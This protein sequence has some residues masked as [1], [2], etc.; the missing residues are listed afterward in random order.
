M[1]NYSTFRQINEDEDFYLTT[2]SITKNGMKFID[3]LL[4]KDLVELQN[5]CLNNAIN[6][7][8]V[9]L[10]RPNPEIELR[11]PQIVPVL[12]SYANKRLF[13][14]DTPGLGKTVMS[15]ESYASYKLRKIKNNEEYKK[16][17]VV[18][19]TDHVKGFSNEWKSFGINLLPLFN[20][21]LKIERVLSKNNIEDFD[22]IILN[23]DSL[24]T[25]A[26]IEHYVTNKELYDFAIFDE[27]TQI[28]NDKSVISKVTDMIVNKY[29]GGLGHVI[30]L[31][32]TSFEKNV[33]D[34]Y[35]QF[36]ILAPKLIPSKK[37]LDS[38]YVV[39]KGTNVYARHYINSNNTSYE[40]MV[41]H[42]TA[43]IINYVN[44]EELKERL[45]YYFI[46]RS[47]SEFYKD[48]PKHINTLHPVYMTKEQL[49]YLRSGLNVS[50]INS[51]TTSNP[52]AKFEISNTP[53]LR[54]IIDF[55]K[56]VEQDRPIIYVFNKEAQ[57][58]IKQELTK[59]NYR[60]D[61]LNGDTK[62]KNE[63][64][65]KFNSQELDMLVTNIDSAINLPTSD[66]ILF[67]DIPTNPQKTTQICGRIDRNND[68]DVKFYDFFCYMYSPEMHNI[69]VNGYF[70]EKHSSK[71]TGQESTRY[72]ELLH[73][74]KRELSDENTIQ[75]YITIFENEE[76][77]VKNLV[78]ET[79]QIN[80][81][82][83]E[84]SKKEGN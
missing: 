11:L 63:M 51:P 5:R 21:S 67:Y 84:I 9:L 17:I 44:Q 59:L 16:V 29:Q 22:G 66:R 34:F 48:M 7:L 43:E 14:G 10:N 32:G 61:I 80:N 83:A 28:I 31:N 58:K 19:K 71:F 64:V 77:K 75:D 39:K 65:E 46:A 42:N 60:V 47:K 82:I 27:T 79:A 76:T 30:F 38:R 40:A 36:K 57:L 35:N 4:E 3:R 73:Q 1:N 25:N 18:T 78:V 6:N 20:G 24:K 68:T 50:K 12:M 52:K 37:F 74:L 15:A 41:S 8:A 23:W 72:L 13:I 69:F 81:I 53:K 62:D 70:R 45:K 56:Q 49:K 33:Y 2:E 55:A 26:F 54:D